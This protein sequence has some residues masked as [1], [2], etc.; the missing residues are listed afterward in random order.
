MPEAEKRAD[1]RAGREE[2]GLR[3]PVIGSKAEHEYAKTRKE[4]AQRNA[5][6]RRQCVDQPRKLQFVVFAADE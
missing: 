6:Q 1:E 2:Q 5:Q 3:R 4:Q